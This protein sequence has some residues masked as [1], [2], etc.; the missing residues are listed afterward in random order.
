MQEAHL[1]QLKNRGGE[2]KGLNRKARKTP[3]DKELEE[4]SSDNTPDINAGH[5]KYERLKQ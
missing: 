5:T 2:E 4:L 3:T 1:Q